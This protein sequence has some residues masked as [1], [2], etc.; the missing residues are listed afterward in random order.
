MHTL[1]ED[2][3]SSYACRWEQ[4]SHYPARRQVRDPARHHLSEA[5][6]NCVRAP[7]SPSFP[8]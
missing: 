2:A 6:R 1:S 4:T 7:I 5:W 3:R 8:I